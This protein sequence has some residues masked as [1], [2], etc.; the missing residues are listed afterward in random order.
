M[1]EA[2]IALAAGLLLV[3]GLLV[4]LGPAVPKTLRAVFNRASYGRLPSRPVRVARP[5]I[6]M[7][8]TTGKALVTAERI[9]DLL[10][11]HGLE[12]H[13]NAV[14]HGIRR[15]Q[16]DEAGGI[17]ALQEV[18]RHL[19]GVKLG[20]ADDQEIFDGLLLQLKKTLGDRAEQLE[21]LPRG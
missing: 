3:A 14:S 7:H 6:D 16:G 4:I 11:E 17:Y 9:R 13:S 15:L 20:D 10:K 12:R 1:L 2:V 21:L 18:V 8:P 5:P 19:R